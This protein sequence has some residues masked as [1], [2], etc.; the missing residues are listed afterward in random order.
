MRT[1]AGLLCLAMCGCVVSVQPVVS[2]TGATLDARLVGTWGEVDGKDRIVV[3]R[4]D[5]N[6][7]EIQYTEG[8]GKVGHFEA[9]L[10]RLGLR[11]V[12]DVQPSP[13]ESS[14]MPEGPSLIRGHIIY[15]VAIAADSVRMQ[16][17]DPKALRAAIKNKSAAL[18]SF[19]DHDQLVLTGGTDELRRVLAGYIEMKGALDDPS[20]WRRVAR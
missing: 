5:A 10:G 4:G 3:S 7:Y 2:A 14:P 9:R 12:I 11:T 16:L 18:G 19:D 8:D 20:T 17:L 15:V 1:L 13:R 6:T